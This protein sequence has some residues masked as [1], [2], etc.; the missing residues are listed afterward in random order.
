[1]ATIKGTVAVNMESKFDN[2]DSR[3]IKFEDNST[4][5]GADKG[6]SKKL[7]RGWKVHVKVEGS[8]NDAM[9]TK[10]KVLEESTAKSSGKRGGGGGGKSGMSKEEWAAKDKRIQ[11]EH[12]Q[13]V[14]ASLLELQLSAGVFK[15]PAKGDKEAVFLTQYD[16]LVSSVFED[17]D[18]YAAVGRVKEE[19]QEDVEVEAD[20]FDED[21][22]EDFDDED[23]D[24]FDD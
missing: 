13:K 7:T 2:D 10:V 8:G 21:E 15:I 9:I 1:M 4:W 14:G 17:I 19:S 3:R 5:Y 6:L 22:D 16:R 12:A 11:Y 18:A 23:D 20:D 24:E